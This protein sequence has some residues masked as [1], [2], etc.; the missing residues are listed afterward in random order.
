VG[1]DEEIR[2]YFWKPKGIRDQ[3]VWAALTYLVSH[4]CV[5]VIQ[6]F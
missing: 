6:G 2:G 5:W 1:K 4:W 3:N